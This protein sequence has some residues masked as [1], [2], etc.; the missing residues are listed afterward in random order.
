MR[1]VRN[2]AAGIGRLSSIEKRCYC[3]SLSELVARVVRRVGL[4]EHHQPTPC[5]VGLGEL[6]RNDF[7]LLLSELTRAVRSRFAGISWVSSSENMFC[8]CCQNKCVL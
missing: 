1:V 5:L 4:L 3:R 2:R 8:S 6:K 7:L